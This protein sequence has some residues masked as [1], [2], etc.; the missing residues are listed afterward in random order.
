[1]AYYSDSGS[2]IHSGAAGLGSSKDI[3]AYK[4]GVLGGVGAGPLQAFKDGS[5]GAAGGPLQAFEDGS[6]GMPLFLETPSGS[7]QLEDPVVI[8]HGNLGG[9]LQ[10][11]KDGVLGEYFQSG[12]GEYFTGM[13]GCSSCGQSDIPANKPA[14]TPILNLSDP[15]VMLELKNAIAAAPWLLVHAQLAADQLEADLKNPKWT[16][17]TRQLAEAWMQGYGPWAASTLNSGGNSNT[18]DVQTY[19]AAAQEGFEPPSQIP[20][21]LGVQAIWSVLQFAFMGEDG[22][23]KN[24]MFTPSQFPNLLQFVAA[25]QA[26]NGEGAVAYVSKEMNTANMVTFGIGALAVAGILYLA[27]K[28]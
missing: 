23:G 26:N 9:T 5:L 6:L 11:Y 16:D 21:T 22:Q 4:D 7:M 15:A 27:L 24:A 10:A 17:Y 28:K 12:V 1:M 14:S 20:N 8:R 3:M 25:V 19:T 13:A 18:T 2:K